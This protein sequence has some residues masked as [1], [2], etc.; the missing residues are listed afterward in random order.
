[1]CV[2]IRSGETHVM[3]FHPALTRDVCVSTGFNTCES[4][5]KNKFPF[6]SPC[7]LKSIESIIALMRN[8]DSYLTVALCVWLFV[9]WDVCRFVC[10][11]SGMCVGLC[12]C[13]LGCV[14]VCVLFLG[15]MPVRIHADEPC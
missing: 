5:P 4:T 12:V 9:V 6:P 13:C 11:L 14:C 15:G 1:M 7:K 8:L 2:F 10:L 3:V